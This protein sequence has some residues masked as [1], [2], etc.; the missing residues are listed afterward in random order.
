MGLFSKKSAEVER[1]EERIKE[2]CGGFL[3]ND[4]FQSKLAENNLGK[5]TSN[6][7][8]KSI[9][10]DEIKNNTLKYEDIEK[11]LDE[12][13]KLDVSALNFK[14]RMSK[15]D[16]SL[17]K[18][19]QDINNFLGD[20][21]TQKHNKSVE[22]NLK[23]EMKKKE[24]ERQKE[25]RNKQKE[26][27]KMEKE[28]QKELRNNQKE[29]EKMERQRQK[30]LRN[31]QKEQEKMKKDV[32]KEMQKMDKEYNEIKKL[33]NKFNVDLIG[34]TWFKC[35]IEE[36][37]Y[38]TFQNEAHRNSDNAYVIINEDNFEILKESVWI[39]SNMGTRKIFF[40]NIASIDFDAR[41]RLHLSSSV[42]IN[43]KSAE[44]IQL[45]FVSEDNFNLL[46]D[47]YEDY[48]RKPQDVPIIS[49]TSKA[50]DLVKYA[51]L[52][53]KGLIT[54]EEFTMM[55]KEIIY[56]QS[57]DVEVDTIEDNKIYCTNCGCEVISEA[58]FCPS[59]GN[60]FY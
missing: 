33:E 36:I 11:R 3:S 25:L 35:T 2:L 37:K 40:D 24:K 17:F 49:Q 42:I 31:N 20:K 48:I 44:H 50:D 7:N 26:Q 54:Q 12:L 4:K 47:A 41:G 58:K 59:C 51:E 53:E 8:Y 55:K 13:M 10:Q 9:L 28:R 16:T 30:E 23:K 57:D 18:T 21:Y 45:K 34:K 5:S 27:E 52:F 15:E 32:Q 46:N 1:A 60:R 19:Q 38:S 56:D 22:K 39:K 43:T 29:Q 6:S 14:I